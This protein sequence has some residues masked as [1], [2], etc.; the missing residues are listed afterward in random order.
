MFLDPEL[1]LV[2]LT[3]LL[4]LIFRFVFI[5]FVV[6]HEIAPM[7]NRRQW[8]AQSGATIVFVKC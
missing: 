3:N 1:T 4:K 7:A 8:T 2:M 5:L 6:S